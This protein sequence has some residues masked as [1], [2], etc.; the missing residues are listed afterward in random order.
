MRV[1]GKDISTPVIEKPPVVADADAA[2]DLDADADAA[3]GG[4]DTEDAAM[5][6]VSKV[7]A[8]I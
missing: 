5:G 1:F 8:D 3:D 7:M 2:E 4:E 6:E